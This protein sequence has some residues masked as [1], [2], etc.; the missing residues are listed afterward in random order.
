[1]DTQ[2]CAHTHTCTHTAPSLSCHSH[3]LF[4]ETLPTALSV[5]RLSS[6]FSSST[7]QPS[8]TL[9]QCASQS[10][11]SLSGSDRKWSWQPTNQLITTFCSRTLTILLVDMEAVFKVIY[12]VITAWLHENSVWRERLVGQMHTQ[13]VKKKNTS[14][15]ILSWKNQH[16][17]TVYNDLT[18]MLIQ[19]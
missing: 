5:K 4:S 9:C 16:W 17:C 6:H 1:M 2:T 13:Q 14:I 8:V 3:K 19:A 10:E 15:V 7:H 18:G 11:Q 12:G